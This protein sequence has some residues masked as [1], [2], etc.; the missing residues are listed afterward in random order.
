MSNYKQ[1][2]NKAGLKIIRYFKAHSWFCRSRLRS[3]A[4]FALQPLGLLYYPVPPSFRRSHCRRQMPPRSTRRERS[5]KRKVELYG[6]EYYPIIYLNADFHVTF[7]NLLHAANLRYGTDGFT[8]PPKEGV[9]RIF[10]PLKI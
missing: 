1:E 7:R 6:R 10:S 8:P 3:N 9:L 2:H 4:P 5:K